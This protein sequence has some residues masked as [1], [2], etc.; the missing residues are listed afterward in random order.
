MITYIK[1]VNW[2]LFAIKL[3]IPVKGIFLLI[4]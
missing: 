3:E 4:A 2:L 1:Q